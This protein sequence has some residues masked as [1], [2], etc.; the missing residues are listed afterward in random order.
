MKSRESHERS[1]EPLADPPSA[2]DSHLAVGTPVPDDPELLLGDAEAARSALGL[3]AGPDGPHPAA[4][5][6]SHDGV[7]EHDSHDGVDQHDSHD[8]V[9]Q[10]DNHESVDQQDGT[11]EPAGRWSRVTGSAGRARTAALAKLGGAAGRLRGSRPYH[12]EA[13]AVLL[14]EHD[15]AT[16]PARVPYLLVAGLAAGGL[17]AVV[18]LRRRRG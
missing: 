18:V 17:A 1:T 14:P 4:L 8:G 3:P 10:H 12:P 2:A 5:H 11:D 15:G 16:A 7:V 6:D 13:A 9:D